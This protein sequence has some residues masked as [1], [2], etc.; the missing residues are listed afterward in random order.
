MIASRW[1]LLLL[2]TILALAAVGVGVGP[3]AMQPSAQRVTVTAVVGLLAPLF[4]PG[5]ALTPARTAWRVVVWSAAA[6][7][8]AAAALRATG[9]AMQ[10]YPKILLSCAVLMLMLLVAHA[11]AA[12]LESRLRSGAADAQGARETAGRT[13][14][15]ALVLL[16]SLPLWAG[17]LAELVSGRHGWAV[18]AVIGVSPLTHLAVASG[19]DLLRNQW[20]YQHANLAGL[21]F[22]YPG[23]VEVAATYG[24]ACLVLAV[25]TIRFERRRRGLAIATLSPHPTENTP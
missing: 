10:P 2:A 23:L 20:F 17:P 19:N 11:L 24:S 3:D 21:Q 14:A 7:M 18:D 8:L 12:A 16:A 13:V 5:V 22:A 15:L 4:W 9:Q 6:A 1:G 25:G